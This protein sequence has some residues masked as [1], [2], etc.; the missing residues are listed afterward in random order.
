MRDV[1]V[2][3]AELERPPAPEMPAPFV[4]A[5]AEALA[6]FRR[7]ISSRDLEADAAALEP[8]LIHLRDQLRAAGHEAQVNHVAEAVDALERRE[9]QA[10]PHGAGRTKEDGFVTVLLGAC[11]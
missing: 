9:A 8:H 4:V 2:L 6:A 3:L 1:P 5:V 11:S 7:L 10:L